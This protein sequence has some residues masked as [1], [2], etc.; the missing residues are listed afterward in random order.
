MLHVPIFNLICGWWPVA[1]SAMKN[2]RNLKHCPL[3]GSNAYECCHALPDFFADNISGWSKM[4]M[5]VPFLGSIFPDNICGLVGW[6]AA[7]VKMWGSERGEGRRVPASNTSEQ[8]G[9]DRVR[10]EQVGLDKEQYWAANLTSFRWTLLSS[11]SAG[12]SPW[13][14]N[15]GEGRQSTSCSTIK[16]RPFKVAYISY[17]WIPERGNAETTW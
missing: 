14:L 6:C 10:Y 13:T 8:P 4:Y 2:R 11:E 5:R 3:S 15:N 1:A 9:L 12:F 17:L 7:K 16:S